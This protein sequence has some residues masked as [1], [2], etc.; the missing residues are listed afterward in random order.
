[1]NRHKAKQGRRSGSGSS[2]RPQAPASPHPQT[3][4]ARRVSF[5]EWT[6]FILIIAVFAVRPLMSEIFEHVQISFLEESDTG[7][8]TAATVWMDAILLAAATVGFA[9]P[10]SRWRA[11]GKFTAVGVAL[12]LMAVIVSTAAAD[13][14]RLAA[15]A[16]ASL[17]IGVIALIALIRLMRTPR[18]VGLALAAMLATGATTAWKCIAWRWYEFEET[19]QMWLQQREE[20]AQRGVDPGEGFVE[21]FTR[22][23]GSAESSGYFS[24]PNN[25]GSVLTMWLLAGGG[26]LIGFVARGVRRADRDSPAAV[27]LLSMLCA[28]FA[29][30]LWLT[31][32][33]GANV[34]LIAGLALLPPFGLAGDWIARRR[35]LALALLAGGYVAIVAAGAA[36]GAAKGTLPHPSL[37]FRWHYWSAAGQALAQSPWTGVGR[38]NFLQQYLLFKPPENPEQVRNAH[39]LW[40]TLWVELGLAGLAAGVL[41]VLAWAY[42][43]LQGLQSRG[44]P[45]AAFADGPARSR[46]DRPLL[47]A[48]TD[49]RLAMVALVLILHAAF[50][51]P[52]LSHLGVLLIWAVEIGLLWTAV[53]LGAAALLT[54]RAW[55]PPLPRWATAGLIAAVLGSLVHNLVGFTLFVPA[56]LGVFGVLAATA[57]AAGRATQSEGVI[58][59]PAQG[60]ATARAGRLGGLIAAAASVALLAIHVVYVAIPTTRTDLAM[61]E[62]RSVLV[63][64]TDLNVLHRA[65]ATAEQAVQSDRW[66]AG[67]A[68]DLAGAA[69]SVAA[70][71]TMPNEVRL[72][73]A[74]L[75]VHWAGEARARAPNTPANWRLIARLAGSLAELQRVSEQP[76]F[77]EQT[78]RAAADAWQEAVRL[79]PTNARTR[80]DAGDAL[81]RLWK[82]SGDELARRVA[83]EH[84]Q[85]ALDLNDKFAAEEVMRLSGEQ[86]RHVAD[87][88]RALSGASQPPP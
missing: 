25:A 46:N 26:L 36:Y 50:G 57:V 13:N 21:N 33:A 78:R 48:L 73:W 75:A 68:L 53:F 45:E 82:E 58:G 14:R 1:L 72:D 63:R 56:G 52:G 8:T 44:K 5:A 66:D 39:E 28:A 2:A 24:H 17:F 61:H 19:R 49:G 88:L 29:I 9:R 32:S 16:G 84:Y 35:G 79:D 20:L 51:R 69:F 31:H 38:E 81:A 80:I 85:T 6:A 18:M 12:L 70:A 30:G 55:E 27:A 60:N 64:P 83:A 71:P 7:P 59:E 3:R 10:L 42:A 74:R 4:E 65:M 47:S 15:N 37:A 76:A 22:R 34:G 86:L 23:L 62:L 87:Q 40:L 41:L 77:A 11:A 67:S 43:A 54:G